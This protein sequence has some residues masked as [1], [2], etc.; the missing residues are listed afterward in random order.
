MICFKKSMDHKQV[1]RLQL[2]HESHKI[3]C[4][5]QKHVITTKHHLYT[6]L[7][8]NENFQLQI[9]RVSHKIVN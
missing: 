2:H 3:V 1:F 8:I 9:F 4:V 7:S 5:S 6:H